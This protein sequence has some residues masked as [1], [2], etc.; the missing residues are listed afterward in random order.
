MRELNAQNIDEEACHLGGIAELFVTRDKT[1]NVGWGR[2][3]K[4]VKNFKF[5]SCRL[6]ETT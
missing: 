3:R 6:W 2:I 5:V 4:Y 1:G